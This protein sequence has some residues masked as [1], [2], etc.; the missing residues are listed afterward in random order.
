LDF[1]QA[2]WQIALD[3]DSQELFSIQTP[4][5]IYTPTRMMQGSQD[6]SHPTTF[7]VLSVRCLM[8]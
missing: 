3:K 1:P 2:F 6:A 5:G 8:N 4:L 7:M